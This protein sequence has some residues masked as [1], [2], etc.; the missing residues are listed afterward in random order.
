MDTYTRLYLIRHGQVTNFSER[1][2][3]G[4][5]DVDITELGIRQMEA[6]ADR[7]KNEKLADVYCSDLIR[8]KK[9]AEI[10]ARAHGLIPEQYSD[11]REL[12]VGLWEGLNMEEIEERF[13]GAINERGRRIVNYRIPEGES[14]GDLA[15]RVI[16]ALKEVLDANHG[17]NIVLVAHGGV[18]RVILAD[19]MNLD[20]KNF[21]SIEQSFGCLNI[22]DYF[23]Q[24]AVIKL[25]NGQSP[26]DFDL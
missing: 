19:A 6:V 13:P 2:Y 21:Y 23:P 14:I 11:L 3:N 12:N 15:G 17:G 1:R 10:I 26:G 9:G 4:H 7:L 20:L 8:T 16:P 18:N 24:L 22:I 5:T 25:I